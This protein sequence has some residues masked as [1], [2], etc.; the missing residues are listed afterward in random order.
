MGRFGLTELLL[1]FG[2]VLLLFGT[3]RLRNLGGDLGNALK[4]FRDAMKDDKGGDKVEEQPSARVIEGEA[5]EK[6]PER[7]P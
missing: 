1:I 3:K 6:S 7:Q 4:G 5:K 2:I